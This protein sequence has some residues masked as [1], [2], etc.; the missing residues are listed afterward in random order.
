MTSA[1]AAPLT[2]SRTGAEAPPQSA[3]L[4]A[5]VAPYARADS[6]QGYKSFALDLAIYALGIAGV[7][8]FGNVVGKV[9]GGL[10]A[11]AGLVN[12][13]SLSHEAAHRS[14]VKSKLGNKVI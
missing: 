7:L 9:A 6:F 10:V 8:F 1:L 4:H 3:E 2:K 14:M 5:R 12:L 13:G 11:G